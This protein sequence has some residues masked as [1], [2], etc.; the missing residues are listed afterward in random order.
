VRSGIIKF[1][2]FPKLDGF[3]MTATAEFPSGTPP[4]VTR[5]AIEEINAALMRLEEKTQTRSG[6]PGRRPVDPGRPDAG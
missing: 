6:T 2:V 4:E 1:E 3:I 5:R